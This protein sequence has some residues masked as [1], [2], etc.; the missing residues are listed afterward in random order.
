MAVMN[1]AGLGFFLWQK[2]SL[3]SLFK[4]PVWC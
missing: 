3:Q 4:N 1:C 2:E